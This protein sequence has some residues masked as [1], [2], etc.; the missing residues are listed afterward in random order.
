[1]HPDWKVEWRRDEPYTLTELEGHLFERDMRPDLSVNR[2]FGA[3]RN[4]TV[5]DNLR[6]IAYREVRKFK[7]RGDD[8]RAW[9]DRCVELA[10]ELNLQFPK[11][12]HICE[13]RALPRASRNGPGKISPLRSSRPSSPIEASGVW[14]RA[15]TG[16]SSRSPGKPWA[17]PRPP[18][19]AAK[20]QERSIRPESPADRATQSVDYNVLMEGPFRDRR[21]GSWT[22]SP[23][24][25]ILDT[26]PAE[27]L[28]H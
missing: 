20:Q 12:M 27:F 28:G 17:S 5:F 18:T 26:H 22:G 1:M 4:V 21:G 3:G 13:V 2:T 7:G 6:A 8:V 11:P 23:G 10:L 9:H 25:S 19:T 15:G 14:P 24:R 16:M